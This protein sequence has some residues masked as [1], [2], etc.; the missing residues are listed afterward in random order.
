M[1]AVGNSGHL[2]SNQSVDSI[3]PFPGYFSKDGV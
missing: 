1:N 3:I 2:W